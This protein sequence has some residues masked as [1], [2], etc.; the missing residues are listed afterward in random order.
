[1]LLFPFVNSSTKCYPTFFHQTRFQEDFKILNS[2]ISFPRRF[3]YFRFKLNWI[4]FIIKIW[5]SVIFFERKR[6]RKRRNSI[7]RGTNCLNQTFS[8]FYLFYLLFIDSSSP[9]FFFQETDVRFLRSSFQF[10][11][12]FDFCSFFLVFFSTFNKVFVTGR[13]VV[14]GVTMYVLSISS[15]SEV[16]MVQLHKKNFTTMTK[17]KNQNIFFLSFFQTLQLLAKF[18]FIFLAKF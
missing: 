11:F 3:Q 9:K 8:L 16:E 18:Q 13:E 15:L 14:V 2:R 4:Y 5:T 1:M 17:S 10:R 7:I 6:K 12:S